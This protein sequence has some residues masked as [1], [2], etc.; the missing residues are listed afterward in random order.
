MMNV[1]M[2]DMHVTILGDKASVQNCQFYRTQVDV[3]PSSMP[4]FSVL[5]DAFM[6]PPQ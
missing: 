3:I 2:K 4:R 5:D 1:H 6:E